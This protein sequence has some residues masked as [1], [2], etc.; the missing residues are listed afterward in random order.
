MNELLNFCLD[1]LPVDLAQALSP[2]MV[3]QLSPLVP[4][5]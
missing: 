4:F 3:E 2:E 5:S 1:Q